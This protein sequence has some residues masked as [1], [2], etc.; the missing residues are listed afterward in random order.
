[1]NQGPFPAG[2]LVHSVLVSFRDNASQEQ[3]DQIVSQYRALGETCGGIKAGILFWQAGL[4]L[5]QRKNWHV[6]QFSIFRDNDALQRFRSH[7][8]HAKLSEVMRPIGNWVVGRS[9]NYVSVA[10]WGLAVCCSKLRFEIS[11][12]GHARRKFNSLLMFC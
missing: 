12:V 3:R 1:M 7:P 6:V 4:N 2:A 8:A 9:R 11:L 5:D 10:D